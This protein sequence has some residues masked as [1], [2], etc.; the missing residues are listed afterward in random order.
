MFN[1]YLNAKTLVECLSE[2]IAHTLNPTLLRDVM[3]LS[4]CS[5]SHF[6]SIFISGIA[7]MTKGIDFFKLFIMNVIT[8]LYKFPSLSAPTSFP[9]WY[10]KSFCK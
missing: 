8:P 5:E 10:C 6:P 3:Q 4:M 7:F 1:K 2:V 9:S